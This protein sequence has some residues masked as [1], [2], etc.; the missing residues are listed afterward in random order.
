VSTLAY[1]RQAPV[2]FGRRRIG[3]GT[4]ERLGLLRDSH[5]RVLEAE[6]R[7]RRRLE[8]DLHDGAQ[9]RLIALSLE[10]K[11]LEQ[12]LSDHPEACSR[13]DQFQREIEI[14][15]DELRAVARGLHPAVLDHGLAV[16]LD[17]AAALAPVP[18]RVSV[19][20][21]ESLPEQIEVA[22]YFVV[23]E[24]L[25]NIAKHA[26]ATKASVE[27]ARTSRGV[28]IQIVDD[29][30]GGADSQRGSGLRG[31]ADRVEALRGQLR[32]SSPI[33]QG[34]HLSAEIPCV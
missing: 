3:R 27:I 19:D 16:A 21:G 10:L 7:E 6:R 30:V 34:T 25:A 23:T 11:R 12:D 5:A 14:S 26:R 20:T 8:R 33:G 31:L 22:A 18:V 15:L 32:L 1:P 24:S 4:L 13:L 17:Q 28:R 2:S 29:G 9:Q